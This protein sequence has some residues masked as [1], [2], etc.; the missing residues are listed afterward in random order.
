MSP[1]S[2]VTGSC[3][4][5]PSHITVERN[6]RLAVGSG[7]RKSIKAPPTDGEPGG[8]THPRGFVAW[9]SEKFAPSGTG[10]WMRMSARR[11]SIVEKAASARCV[12]LVG[13]Q[14]EPSTGANSGSWGASLRTFA[15]ERVHA[16]S[17]LWHEPHE[18]PLV[19]RLTKNAL[20]GP[21][22]KAF[23][24]KLA[25]VPAGS[26]AVSRSSMRS[27]P[28]FAAD[29]ADDES[30]SVGAAELQP[31]T[32]DTNATVANHPCC[33]PIPPVCVPATAGTTREWQSSGPRR[34]HS[35]LPSSGRRQ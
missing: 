21:V 35:S 28:S 17:C 19:P 12:G 33:I 25:V 30:P 4:S 18:R 16:S 15:A 5:R 7:R 1:R 10:S 8:R 29:D 3:V 20:L 9:A 6:S 11:V 32:A 34:A 27:P 24:E 31:C 13:G 22:S 26:A 2:C 14:S 23:F